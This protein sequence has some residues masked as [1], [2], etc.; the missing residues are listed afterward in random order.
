V[1][2][3]SPHNG[4]TEGANGAHERAAKLSGKKDP[5][6]RT[7]GITHTV[8]AVGCHVPGSIRFSYRGSFSKVS[9]ISGFGWFS[10]VS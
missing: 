10:L 2:E 4:D 8:V 9:E 6:P 5:H 1:W 3:R 7:S